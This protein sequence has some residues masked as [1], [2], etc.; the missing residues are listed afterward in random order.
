MFSIS[1]TNTNTINV[2]RTLQS[3]IMVQ[4]SIVSDKKREK[5]YSNS[6]GEFWYQKKK[7]S[8]NINKINGRFSVSF[9]FLFFL[10]FFVFI[11]I[12]AI[13]FSHDFKRYWM[14]MRII[15]TRNEWKNANRCMIVGVCVGRLFR[16]E[17]NRLRSKTTKTLMYE[18][19]FF[20]FDH[21]VFI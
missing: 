11:P 7:T 20:F 16:F 12:T 9:S 3:I 18:N 6:N 5:D 2:R 4:K 1:I 14:E 21:R 10:L 13:F 19:L 15:H 17:E 8:K